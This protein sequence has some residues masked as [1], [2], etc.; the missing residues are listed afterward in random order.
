MQVSPGQ[1]GRAAALLALGGVMA[2]SAVACKNGA[3]AAGPPPHPPAHVQVAVATAADVPEYLDEIGK[4]MARESVTIMPQ[5][6]GRIEALHFADGANLKKGDL[7][8]TIDPR[9]FQAVLDQAQGQLAK[10]QA[11]SANADRFLNRQS[12]IYKQGFVSPSDYDTA[13]FNA[14]AAKAAVQ[15]DE[16]SIEAAK[17]NV[18]YCNIRSPIDGRAGLRLVD[19]G[20]VVKINETPLLVIQRLDPIYADFTINESQLLR[21]RQ[22]MDKGILKTLVKLPEDQDYREGE[23][24]FLD[25]AVQDGTGT[26]KLRATLSNAERHFWPGQFVNV[27]LVLRV[28]KGAVLAPTSVPQQSQQGAYALVVKDKAGP[29]G[30]PATFA[31][32]RL[33]TLGQRQGDLIVIASGVAAG[34]RVITDG[35]MLVRPGDPVAILPPA[36]QSV[37][38]ASPSQTTVSRILATAPTTGPATGP[39]KNGGAE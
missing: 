25:N 26:V 27:R 33:I 15:A 13:L 1:L 11:A 32:L 5:V 16:A 37:N 29:D 36:T 34:E 6:A 9:P 20:N 23:L 4:A 35:Q 10:D 39:A 30:K 14:K 21:V 38:A 31:E 17:L 3:E 18:E 28:L 8:F 12:D 2:M 7:L 24:S 22:Q 19:P